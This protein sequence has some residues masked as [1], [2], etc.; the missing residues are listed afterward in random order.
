MPSLCFS[1]TVPGYTS[2][3]G[4]KWESLVPAKFTKAHPGPAPADKNNHYDLQEMKCV[5]QKTL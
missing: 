3:D 5:V 4:T 2:N 1:Q